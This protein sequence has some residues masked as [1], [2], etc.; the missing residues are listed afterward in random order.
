MSGQDPANF[1]KNAGFSAVC[2]AAATPPGQS[3]LQVIRLSGPGSDMAASLVFQP[4]GPRFP[5]VMDMAGYTCSLGWILD[6]DKGTRIDQALLTRFQS[7]H[8]Y[9]GEDMIEISCHGSTAVKQAVLDSLFSLGVKPAEPGEFTRR[10]FLNGKMDLA[11]AEAVMDLISSSARKASEAAAAQLQGALSR[12]VRGFSADAYRLL[13][14]VELILEYPEHDDTAP[15]M[16]A[17]S[18]D[19]S[20]LIGKISGLSASYR[21]GRLLREGMTVVIAGRPNSGKSSLLNSLAGY[22]RAIVTP[23]PGTTRDTVEE[24]VDIAGLPVRLVDTA[25]LRE[26][27]DAV[28][29]LGVDRAREALRQADLIIWLISPPMQDLDEEVAEIRAAAGMPLLLVAGKDDLSESPRLRRMLLEQWPDCRTI[30]FSAVTGEGLGEIRQAIL[31]R[32]AQSGA[33]SDEEVLITNSRHKACLDMASGFLCQAAEV[34][35]DGLTLDVAA[36]LIRGSIEKLAEITGDSV[37]DEL[38]RTIFSRFCV[39]K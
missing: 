27:D 14:Q 10:A 21:Q 6:A 7:P 11:Q 34:L 1:R 13:S 8:S 18:G 28:E 20:S 2:A 35:R 22:D 15:A 23:V 5:P 39:G 37:T 3:G 36:S 24:Q 19:L 38:I 32:Y 31:D 17:L 25:G 16:A 9:T 4:Q 33:A 29:R 26:T 30:G 12:K